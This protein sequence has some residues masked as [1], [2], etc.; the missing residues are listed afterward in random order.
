MNGGFRN[1]PAIWISV[2]KTFTQTGILKKGLQPVRSLMFI[3]Y[4]GKI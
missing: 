1:V 2:S 3:M 4:N